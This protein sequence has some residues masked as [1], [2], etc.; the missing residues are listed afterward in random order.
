MSKGYRLYKTIIVRSPKTITAVGICSFS[1]KRRIHFVKR[2]KKWTAFV[3]KLV[4]DGIVLAK[5][6]PRPTKNWSAEQMVR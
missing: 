3:V 6:P 2:G 4:H 5:V 1:I